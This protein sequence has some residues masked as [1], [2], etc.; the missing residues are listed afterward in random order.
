[1]LR[2][3]RSA[4]CFL[5]VGPVS[6]QAQTLTAPLLP[7]EIPPITR[8][9]A[10]TQNVLLVGLRVAN[11]FDDNA[12]NDDR[13]KQGNLV[14]LVEPQIGWSLSTPR[15]TWMLDYRPGFSIAHPISI[16]D[17]RSQLLDTNLQL[18]PTKRLQLRMRENLL[19]S[20]NVFEQLQ[21]T[22]LTP[23]SSVLDRP[24]NS[25]FGAVRENSE[26]AGGDL[27]YALTSRTL[28]GVSAAFY[29]VNYKSAFDAQALGSARSAG[30]HAFSS[31]HLTRH[32]W[33]GFDYNVQ[34]ISSQQPESRSLIQ[35]L[36]YTDTLLLTPSMS[37]SFFVGPQHLLTRGVSDS[38]FA[39]ASG[40]LSAQAN[41]SWAGGANYLWSSPRTSLTFGLSRRIS[42]GA[43]LQG[44]VQLFSASVEVEHQLTEHW[45]GH[46]LVSDNHN[47]ALVSSFTPL[48][49][50]SFAGGLSRALNQR[51][52]VECQ[53]WHVYETSFAGSLSSYLADHNRISMSLRYDLKAPLQR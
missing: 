8:T 24:N 42:D 3:I 47:T 1:M 52:S 26:Q 18:A 9:E 43:G 34:D 28:I 27:S 50:V 49:Y 31:Y 16:Y 40:P 6:L 44:V 5:L 19:Q 15:V 35:S 23:G 21:Q 10:G 14:T 4:I 39:S 32:H 20:K 51:L 37:V 11:E 33:V 13:N 12:L 25:I 41:W 38:R 48:S 17:S 7:G 45:K 2:L 22:E 30:A 29:R 53:Y 36:L 46:L